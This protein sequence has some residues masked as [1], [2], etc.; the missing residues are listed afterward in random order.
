[1]SV[2]PSSP[3]LRTQYHFTSIVFLEHAFFFILLSNQAILTVFSL[4]I[5]KTASFIRIGAHDQPHLKGHFSL[6]LK[7]TP[8]WHLI[9]SFLPWKEKMA[10]GC[11]MQKLCTW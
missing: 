4:A 11:I 9:G 2:S 10:D 7:N 1:L 8:P 5:Q 6:V 3:L